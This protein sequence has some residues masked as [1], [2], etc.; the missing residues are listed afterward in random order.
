MRRT[1][2]FTGKT[3]NPDYELT[4]LCARAMG[5]T[6]DEQGFKE[7]DPLYNDEHLIA[8][9]KNLH[10]RHQVV[11]LAAAIYRG[12]EEPYEPSKLTPSRRRLF[13]P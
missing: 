11:E 13:K 9:I 1:P 10:M 8:L 5:W 4:V 6:D 3:P 2:K 12:I 7:F